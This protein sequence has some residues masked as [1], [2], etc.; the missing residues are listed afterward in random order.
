MTDTTDIAGLVE[1]LRLLV[2]GKDLLN[3][4]ADFG[5]YWQGCEDAADALTEQAATIASQAAQIQALERDAGRYR[6]L[7]PRLEVKPMQAVSGSVRPALDVRIGWSYMDS[8]GPISSSRNVAAD[9]ES[10]DAA[11]DSAQAVGDMP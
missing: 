1:R 3:R 9:C 4:T 2:Q 10:L 7:R 5:D 11:I 8:K 6:W